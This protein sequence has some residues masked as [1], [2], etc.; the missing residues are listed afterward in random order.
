MLT[1]VSLHAHS[2]PQPTTIAALEQ[3]SQQVPQ[4]PQSNSKFNS[5]NKPNSKFNSQLNNSKFSSLKLNSKFNRQHNSNSSNN[6]RVPQ[7]NSKQHLLLLFSQQSHPALLSPMLNHPMVLQQ[8]MLKALNQPPFKLPAQLTHSTTEMSVFAMLA[9][10][11]LLV[12]A[13]F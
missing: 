4:V 11:T 6:N 10:D 13:Q 2:E 12:N 3:P 1:P 8:L 5:N 9:T 7:L